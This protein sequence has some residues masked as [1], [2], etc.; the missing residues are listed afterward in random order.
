MGAERAM[1]SGVGTASI[2]LENGLVVGA[3][4][5]VNAWGDV[6]DP[7]T[8]KI[9]AGVRSE[10]GKGFADARKLVRSGVRL[11]GLAGRNTTIGVV[12]TNA[13]LDK[14]QAT[15]VAQMAHDGVARAI[16]PAHTPFDGDTIFALATGV[17]DGPHDL[18]T[19]GE[20]AAQATAEAIVRAVEAAE[21]AA[22]FP[23]A[24]DMGRR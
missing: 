15:K 20:L 1:K 7:E 9:V 18:L 17:W 10:D 8:G 23:A 2:R 21:S 12:A 22:G 13:L 6:I 19:I 14:A 5:A 24:R 16:Q 11:E 4:V 3:L